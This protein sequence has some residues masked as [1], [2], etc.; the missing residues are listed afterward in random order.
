MLLEFRSTVTAAASGH[1]VLIIAAMPIHITVLTALPAG[2]CGCT[3]WP[4]AGAGA[5][6]TLVRAHSQCRALRLL[7]AGEWRQSSQAGA[8]S[9]NVALG[10]KHRWEGCK[11]HALRWPGCCWRAALAEILQAHQHLPSKLSAIVCLQFVWPRHLAKQ[12]VQLQGGMQR[13]WDSAVAMGFHV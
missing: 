11:S 1:I 9:R 3:L 4:G 7:H 2:G 6:G 5:M 13:R 8:L 10:P 12:A